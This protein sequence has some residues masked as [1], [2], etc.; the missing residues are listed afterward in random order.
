[1]IS[2]A[3]RLLLGG[4]L[5]WS[6]ALAVATPGVPR[7][8]AAAALLTLAL[9]LWRASLGL[10]LLAFLA[11]AGW[12]L[13]P[14]PVR[15]AEM[16]TWAFLSGWLLGVWRP[17][18]TAALSTALPRQIVVPAAAC[19][20][21][22]FASW[23]A[24]TLGDAGGID[25]QALPRYVAR[26]IGTDHLAVTSP[27]AETGA[28]LLSLAGLGL[29]LA[30]MALTRDAPALARQVGIALALSMA[31]MSLAMVA[32]AIRQWGANDYSGAF[33]Y[34]YA[35]YERNAYH[36]RDLNAAGSQYVLA[37][38]TAIGLAV[39]DR[40]RRWI[41]LALLA[42]M[43]PGV[44]LT[45]SRTAWLAGGA[46]GALV[47]GTACRPAWRPS[48]RQVVGLV[49]AALVIVL[50]GGAVLARGAY[51]RNAAGRAMRLR[52]QFS[53]TSARML[54][55]AP[56]YGVG[57]GR[58]YG[59][60]GEF[61]PAEIRTIYGFE[62]AHNYFAQQFAELGVVG[63]TIFLWLVIACVRTGWRSTGRT[64]TASAGLLAG[65]LGYLV[66]CL[67]GHPLLVPE[68]ALPF[69]AALGVAIGS[70]GSV[71]P[72]GAA[73]PRS[74]FAVALLGVVLIVPIGVAGASYRQNRSGEHGFYDSQRA[75][76]GTTFRW[77]TRH[78]VTYVDAVPGFLTLRMRAQPLPDRPPFV[79]TTELD[80][81]VI[82]RRVVRADQW[83]TIELPV[84]PRTGS[85]ATR[86]RIDLRVNQTW[87]RSQTVGRRQAAQPVGVMMAIAWSPIG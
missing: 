29:L 11:P 42:I 83:V 16:L 41:W 57:V 68:A 71:M 25:P 38:L 37:G 75:E 67:T 31:I 82:D 13:A 26:T 3:G 44:W 70:G 84:R 66:T 1:M 39:F 53:E 62:N 56:L 30:S 45:G 59:R 61:M 8:A 87:P 27:E 20:A 32:A 36:L 86:Q 79:L 46:A 80:G 24:L 58:Y 5:A 48:R 17:L 51:Q 28:M 81:R 72:P 85:P 63:G 74:R 22:L 64:A 4:A 12:L 50:A 77:T 21:C 14:D 9:S 43:A 2:A 55:S 10:V 35:R 69:W 73:T 23:L 49:A 33:L 47:I 78:A 76:D 15:A 54:A 34:R 52:V 60:S 18:S 6:V 40:P 65:S 7:I 19:A